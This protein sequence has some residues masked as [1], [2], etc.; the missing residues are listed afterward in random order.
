MGA[1]DSD[2]TFTFAT[3]KGAG[4]MVPEVKPKSA[5]SLFYRFLNDLPMDH[6]EATPLTI[7]QQPA[8]SAADP[9]AR[10]LAVVASGGTAPYSYEWF[11]NDILVAGTF[12]PELVL[13]DE[14]L[15]TDAEY[16]CHVIGALGSTRWIEGVHV[17]AR[18]A[19][20]PSPSP[21]PVGVVDEKVYETVAIFA[22]VGGLGGGLCIAVLAWIAR[23]CSK[24][25]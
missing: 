1:V 25:D 23:M 19:V 6:S 5:L 21:A 20:G 13:S 12:G 2:H 15:S 18:P 22:F 4:H 14:Q 8:L 24:R 11:R 9:A 10:T 7:E 17:A 3:V 16:H